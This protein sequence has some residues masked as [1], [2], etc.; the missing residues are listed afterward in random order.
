MSR[1]P[2]VGHQIAIAI[3]GRIDGIGF[4]GRLEVERSVVGGSIRE[5]SRGNAFLGNS[6]GD[7]IEDGGCGRVVEP[8]SFAQGVQV[9]GEVTGAGSSVGE[10]GEKSSCLK[11]V[12]GGECELAEP[13]AG[14]VVREA[15]QVQSDRAIRTVMELNKIFLPE[16]GIGQPLV[17]GEAIEGP[18]Q[19]GGGVGCPRGR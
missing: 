2:R 9:E 3:G 10:Q 8:E 13:G 16:R 17:D 4:A 12:E 18:K 11:V 6:P 1:F 15:E 5:P 19:S 7:L 14:E